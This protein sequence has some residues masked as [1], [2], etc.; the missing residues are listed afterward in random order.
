MATI[1]VRCL[2]LVCSGRFDDFGKVPG[3][4]EIRAPLGAFAQLKNPLGFELKERK[5]YFLG[6][7]CLQIC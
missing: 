2:T 1:V 6:R 4:G 7:H 3:Q 5:S